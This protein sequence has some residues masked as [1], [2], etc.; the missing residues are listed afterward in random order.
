[1]PFQTKTGLIV[2]LAAAGSTVAHAG[3][4]TMTFVGEA[5]GRSIALHHDAT[6]AWDAGRATTFSTSGFAG[7]RTFTASGR[8]V[9]TFA[10]RIAESFTPGQVVPFATV[11]PRDLPG[12]NPSFGPVGQLRAD[13]LADL[14][15]RYGSHAADDADPSLVAGF[16][17]AIWEI[18]HENLTGVTREDAAAQLSL[19]LGAFQ[20]DDSGDFDTFISYVQANL[21]LASLA[22][23]PYSSF[24]SLRGLSAGGPGDQVASMV[25]PL[26]APAL[27]AAGGLLV[28]RSR[29]RPR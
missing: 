23:G 16:Q 2:A 26:P 17:L 9:R 19:D 12:G 27:L 11:D 14:F 7:A 3:T 4:L 10:V 29:R 6:A 25:V 15:G 5:A 18:M 1:M 28:A 24:S 8:S 20:T 21:M 13:L 22:N